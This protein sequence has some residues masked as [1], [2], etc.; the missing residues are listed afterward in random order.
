MKKAAIL[1]LFGEFNFGNRLQNYAVQEILKK[2]NLEVE[3]IKYLSLKSRPPLQ[4]NDIQKE[5]LAKFKKFNEN[6]RF[7]KDIMYKEDF[8]IKDFAKQFDYIIIGSDQIWNFTYKNGFSEKV[9]ASFA[10]ENIKISLAASFGVECIPETNSEEY[11]ICKEHLQK[12]NSISVREYAGKHI[13]ENLTGRKDVEVLIDPTMMLTRLEWEK[14]MKKP[15]NLKTDKFIIKSFLGMKLSENEEQ[16]YDIAKKNNCEIIDISDKN[17]EYY[18]MGPSEFLYLIKNA[19]LVATDSFH[20]CVFSI[21]FETPFL[22]F[23]RSDKCASMHSRIETLLK[24]FKMEN[25]IYNGEV[26]K[27]VFDYDSITVNKVLFEERNRVEKF[28]LSALV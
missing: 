6:I 26:N 5:R 14:L 11:A 8:V 27:D 16:I 23:E 13:V 21:L 19:F 15:N 1:T 3:T 7:Y 17:S 9:F 20:A 24:T 4:E 10:P 22:V 28:L 12:I 2:F 18:N 25:R